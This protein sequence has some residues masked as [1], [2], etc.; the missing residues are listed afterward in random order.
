MVAPSSITFPCRLVLLAILTY[1]MKEESRTLF[2]TLAGGKE[3]L[4]L[5]SSMVLLSGLKPIPPGS[6]RA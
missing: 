3:V 6:R 5:I 2:R 1:S 4:E